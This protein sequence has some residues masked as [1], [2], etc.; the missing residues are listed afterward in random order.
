[1]PDRINYLSGFRLGPW[2]RKASIACFKLLADSNGLRIDEGVAG[3]VHDALGVGIPH[4]VQC[5]FAHLKDYAVMRNLT[6]VTVEDVREVYRTELLG[7]SGQSDIAHYDTRLTTALDHDTYRI[8]Q[9]ILTEAATKDVVTSEAMRCLECL[10]ASVIEDAPRHIGEAIDVLVHDGYLAVG[11]D[12]GYRFPFRL[13]KDWWGARFRDHYTPL[14]S[15]TPI[16]NR[17][18]FR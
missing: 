11:D 2:D 18:D 3:A 15:R 17:G 8:A 5:Y 13:L 6:C 9:Q 1:M 7:P 12:D 16:E 4:H 10:Y 14:T